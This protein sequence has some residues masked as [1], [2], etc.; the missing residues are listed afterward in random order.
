MYRELAHGVNNRH[1]FLR[2]PEVE[3]W[4]GQESDTYIS[5][6][7]YDESIIDFFRNTGSLR[8]FDGLIYMP[9]EFILDIDTE[10]GSSDYARQKTIA[11]TMKLSEEFKVPHSIY[12]SG[13]G[14]HIGIPSNAF[15]WEPCDDLHTRIKKLFRS[16]GIYD[17]ADISV[18]DK[19][20][21]V[22]LV[23]TKN[24]KSGLYKVQLK[25]GEIHKSIEEIYELAQSPREKFIYD[26]ECDPVFDLTAITPAEKKLR[27]GSGEHKPDPVNY[28]CI[29]EMLDGEN[30]QSRHMTALRIVS[31]LRKSLPEKSVKAIMHEWTDRLG[32]LSGKRELTYDEID[33]IINYTYD[34]NGGDGYN[35]GCLDNVMTHHCK[36]ICRLYK[37]RREE[38]VND[39]SSLESDYVKFI[40]SGVKP[41]DLGGVIG[42]QYYPV[43]PGEF[44]ILQAPPKHMKTTLLQNWVYRFKRR[45]YFLE[46]EM[47]KR[48]MWNTFLQIHTGK[49]ED[50]LRNNYNEFIGESANFRWLTMDFNRCRAEDLHK[51]ILM[52]PYKPELLVIDHMQ[53]LSG[54]IDSHTYNHEVSNILSNLAVKENIIIIAIAEIDKDSMRNGQHMGSVKGG[55][56][57]VYD[58]N[59]VIAITKVFRDSEGLITAMSIKDFANREKEYL[60]GDVSVNNKQIFGRV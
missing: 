36:Q 14:F 33:K 1:F 50:Y 4:E 32:S 53:R 38:P 19:T 49:D 5:L 23:N 28:P 21:L 26:T 40:E 2:S 48:Q 31:H 42:L 35:Y 45:T 3:S 22:R 13:R 55:A 29:Q 7:E 52:M 17:L 27:Y 44:V 37:V 47:S 11:L 12:F 58:A 6:W 10:N 56:A 15:R 59:K 8:G 24:T 39:A 41:I 54:S 20:R 30:I 18:T 9:D 16:N 57:A 25:K 43:Y 34:A 46:M 60:H 51:R